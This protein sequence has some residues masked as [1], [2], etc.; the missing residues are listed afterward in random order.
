MKLVILAA[1][2]ACILYFWGN[3]KKNSDLLSIDSVDKK[4]T[5]GTLSFNDIVGWFKTIK[6]LNK[7]T[8]IPFIADPQKRD[9]LKDKMHVIIN[10]EITE[11]KKGLLLGIFNQQTNK[12]AHLCL[13]EA[14]DFDSKTI[15]TLGSEPF[16]ILG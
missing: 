8:D 13:V 11:G 3:R 1:I 9:C 15:E 2:V 12:I 10:L 6:G 14:D 4:T 5:N 7:T 16:I